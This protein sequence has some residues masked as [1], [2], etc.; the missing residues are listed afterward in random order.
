MAPQGR[1]VTDGEFA[2]WTEWL[3]E[4]FDEKAGPFYHRTE[5]GGRLVAA[6]RA[7][8][9]HTNGLGLVHGGCLFSLADYSLF[10][11]AVQQAGGD[12]VVTVSMN[13]EFIGSARGGDLVVAH[14]EIVKAGRT[15][16]FARGLLKANDKPVLSFSGAMMRVK[17]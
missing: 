11:A 14:P 6:F 17:A 2:G 1:T 12:E 16:V 7:N 8:R 13:G 5:N 10:T 15:M 3:G 4:P 9:S